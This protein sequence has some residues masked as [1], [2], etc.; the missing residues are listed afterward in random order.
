MVREMILE[1]KK[2]EQ[3]TGC[4]IYRKLAS[5]GENLTL[6]FENNKDA[7]QLFLECIITPLAGRNILIFKAVSV[8][9]RTGL[10]L[11]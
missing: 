6:L 9:E 5:K 3:G 10:S 11:T 7:D 8:A 1:K 4:Q 2:Q